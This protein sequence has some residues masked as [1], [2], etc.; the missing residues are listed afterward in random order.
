MELTPPV[1]VVAAVIEREGRFLVAK[2]PSHKR[3]GGLWE[4][5]GGKLQ[6]GEDLVA[7]ARRELAE[8]LG[9]QVQ[10]V[11]PV[12]WSIQDAASI[13]VI[14]FVRTSIVGEPTAREHDALAWV[15]PADLLRYELAP[16]DRLFAIS[17]LAAER[18]PR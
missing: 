13:F 5:P 17:V 6:P 10:S 3:H 12:D 16:T 7:A 11:G 9:V 15:A 8:E 4:F 2:R 1:Q 14:N 18:S